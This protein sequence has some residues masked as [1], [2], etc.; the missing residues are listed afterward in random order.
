MI[1]CGTVGKY[2]F[3]IYMG[4]CSVCWAVLKKKEVVWMKNP[5]KTLSA[6]LGK[7]GGFTLVEMLIVVAIIA[8]LIAVSIPLINTSLE[9]AR[10]ATDQANER[11]AKAEAVMICLGAADL[12]EGKDNDGNAFDVYQKLQTEGLGFIYDAGKGEIVLAIGTGNSKDVVP[13]GKCTGCGSDY[14]PT[15]KAHTQKVIGGFIASDGLITIG[16]VAQYTE[17]SSIVGV[18]DGKLVDKE[19][20]ALS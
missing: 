7:T 16:W 5:V 18:K 15:E 3:S 1:L 6:K 12:G 11:A 2:P 10:D 20:T 8:I 4:D 19:G 13:Y 14:N 17:A 9:K